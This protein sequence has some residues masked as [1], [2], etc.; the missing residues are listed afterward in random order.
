[1]AKATLGIAV[2]AS[3]ATTA[4]AVCQVPT[5]IDPEQLRAA[6]ERL[7][8]VD[9]TRFQLQDGQ[10][11]QVQPDAQQFPDP[12]GYEARTDNGPWLGWVN[13]SLDRELGL[14]PGTRIASRL[15]G[16]AG[17][18][19]F[20]F[21]E[22]IAP[23][24]VACPDGGRQ[25]AGGAPS[26]GY[27]LR[28]GDGVLRL[29]FARPVFAVTVA[30]AP[31]WT[32]S[33]RAEVFQIEGWSN[34]D[35]ALQQQV[36]VS[37]EYVT[38]ENWVQLTLNG[39]QA[40]R[41]SATTA[42][43]GATTSTEF[44]YVIIRAFNANGA[45]INAP[46]LIDDLR[47]AD[48]YGRTPFEALGPRT[49]GLRDMLT[50][51]ARLR[52]NVRDTGDVIR[53]AGRRDDS[54]FP[55]GQRVRMA[56]DYPA[57]EQAALRQRTRV[58][59]RLGLIARLAGERQS[60]RMSVPLLVPLAA[61]NDEDPDA[62]LAD[63]VALME[64]EDFYH[65]ILPTELGEAVITGTRLATPSQHGRSRIGQLEIGRGYAGAR[66]SFNLYGASY[67]VRLSCEGSDIDD[68]PCNDPEALETLLDRLF[69]FMPPEEDRR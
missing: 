48:N 47:F 56:I 57:A 52:P 38:G 66:A 12:G 63:G 1:M 41:Q 53:P 4:A 5:R 44:D 43:T 35:I 50:E 32:Q 65:L 55:V 24:L 49:G 9:P 61:F 51:T 20:G 2:L 14:L 15:V 67:S 64:R 36:A 10:L 22:D 54:L 8:Q 25:C 69:L 31:D 39:Q 27:A 37:P 45:P 17:G 68:E 34:G 30:A 11:Q 60:N 28:D 59:A 42:A 29:D 7:Q 16:T 6:Q 21:S 3:L 33:P 62:G 26:G 23:A 46:I 19:R 40:Q 58:G 18:V 13:F